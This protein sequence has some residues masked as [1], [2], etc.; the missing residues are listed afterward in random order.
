MCSMPAS[1]NT[2]ASPILAQQMP[3]APRSICHLAMTGDLCVFA[4]GRRCMPAAFARRCTWSIL[5]ERRRRSTSTCGVARS[6]ISIRALCYFL[7]DADVQSAQFAGA[8]VHPINFA[9]SAAADERDDFVRT[10]A[11]AG[12]ERHVA[13]AALYNIPRVDDQATE[14]A[15]R[16][17]DG[18]RGRQ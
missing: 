4:C 16:R 7:F 14:A 17:D 9:H 18:A 1:T 13:F 15:E 5:F 11:G 6:P 3:T 10:A 2:S 8:I 12:A